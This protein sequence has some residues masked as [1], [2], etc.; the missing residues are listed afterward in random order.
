VAGFTTETVVVK[1]F[2][3]PVVKTDIHLLSRIRQLR[4]LAAGR[5]YRDTAIL[6]RIVYPECVLRAIMPPYDNT[7]KI[8]EQ[9]RVQSRD[10]LERF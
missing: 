7:F 5:R 4:M 6:S 8:G 3:N 10:M 1:A 9:V 2:R